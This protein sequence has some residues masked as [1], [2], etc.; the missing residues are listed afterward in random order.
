MTPSEDFARRLLAARNLSMIGMNTPHFAPFGAYV[1]GICPHIPTV[2]L[3]A[4]HM[5]IVRPG[6][7]TETVS[8]F[9]SRIVSGGGFGLAS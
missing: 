4:I 9:G 8:C 7:C 2:K 6:Y 3:E 1:T 5:L